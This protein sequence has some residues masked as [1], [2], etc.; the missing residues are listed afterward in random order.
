MKQIQ[1]EIKYKLG[2]TYKFKYDETDSHCPNCG[3]K[4]VWVEHG[5]GD[6]YC[7]PT[8]LCI[9]CN[10]AFY[11]PIEKKAEYTEQQAI[12]QIKKELGL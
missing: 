1:V 12:D 8:Y 11:I 4:S 3:N 6:F 7:G 5:E 9:S 2:H 10:Y